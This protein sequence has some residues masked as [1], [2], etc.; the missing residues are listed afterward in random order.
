MRFC[1]KCKKKFPDTIGFCPL[2]GTTLV[3]EE[4]APPELRPERQRLEN[5]VVGNYQLEEVLAE[6][7]MGIIFMAKHIKLGR[8]A[9]LKMLRPQFS[10]NK[11]AVTRFFRE[12]RAVNEIQHENIIEIT[13]FIEDQQGDN[14]YIM[15]LLEGQDLRKLL[16]KEGPLSVP[17][18]LAIAIQISNALAAVHKAG[19]VHRDMKT[20]NVF[21][22]KR[23]ENPD[24]VKLL[25]FGVAKLIRHTDEEDIH[26]TIEGTILGTAEYMSPEQASG[27][28]VDFRTDIYSLGVI[29]YEMI[30]G[31][32][33]IT[34]KSFSEIIYNQLTMTP[35]RPSQIKDLSINMPVHLEELIM[36]CLEKDPESRPQ[37][38]E[39]MEARLRNIG[40]EGSVQ[41]ETASREFPVIQKSHRAVFWAVTVV[42]LIGLGIGLYF[43]FPPEQ[44]HSE[45]KTPKDPPPANDLKPEPI[46]V[47]P[48][49]LD[50][51]AE[52]IQVLFE[53]TPAGAKI[54]TREGD[55][56]L[57]TTPATL[58]FT[59]TNEVRIFELRLKGH[60]PA[61][62][63]VA[64]T[65]D[66]NLNVKL[67]KGIPGKKK[68]KK[69][70][71]KTGG[72]DIDMGGTVDPF[73]D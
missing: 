49:P 14:Y 28:P 16:M 56:P 43:L 54:F 10:D 64:M 5:K 37:S 52:T 59:R 18:S 4:Q 60:K 32:R 27:K 44:A 29:I 6:G 66:G 19:I 21:M 50:A 9:A 30:S 17:R 36:Q 67:L 7:G 35:I 3:S 13:D 57:G 33:P 48:K 72:T 65:Q 62:R 73:D 70:K 38:M 55:G 41:C 46:P 42:L 12:A 68:K 26:K 51:K 1:P 63:R 58:T 15:E 8:R 23:G 31:R 69:R 47:D 71:K 24:F 40:R 22:V 39:E 20:E 11:K 53:S 45:V 25:D 2:D 61:R 34:G